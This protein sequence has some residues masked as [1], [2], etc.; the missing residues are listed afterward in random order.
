[1]RKAQMPAAAK[2]D[3]RQQA[4]TEDGAPPFGLQMRAAFSPGTINTEDRTVEVIFGSDKPV[5]MFTWEYG[6]I[7]E[8]LSFDKA[9]VRMGRLNG[10]APVLDNHDAYGSVLDTVVGVVEK[11]WL[12]GKKGYASIRFA[13]NEKAQQIMEMVRDGI[14][15]NISVGYAVYRYQRAKAKNDDELDHYKAIDWEPHEISLVSVPADS[16]AKV[17]SVAYGG[18]APS[19]EG[20]AADMPATDTVPD[21]VAE[22]PL[23]ALHEA[24]ERHKDI[25]PQH[26]Y[27][28]ITAALRGIDA[29]D[30]TINRRKRELQILRARFSNKYTQTQ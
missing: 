7:N 6:V 21:A 4:Q 26:T 18:T 25:L 23:I 19:I 3:S 2:T 9:H 20:D 5:R 30:D 28:Q 17:R 27:E 29:E 12:D 22:N 14:L 15:Q 24:V 13:K 8:E 11:A 10:G 16:D 1:M